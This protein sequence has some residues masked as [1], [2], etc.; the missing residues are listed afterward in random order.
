VHGFVAS[1]LVTP[2][3]GVVALV[4]AVWLVL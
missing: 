4:V 3:L 1:H 2:A